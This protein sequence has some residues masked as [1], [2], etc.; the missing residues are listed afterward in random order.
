MSTICIGGAGA[1]AEAR[2]ELERAVAGGGVVLF[3]ADGVYGLGCDPLSSAAIGRIHEIK[4][5]DEGKPAAILYFS[6]LA[7][8]ELLPSLGPRTQDAIGALLP[9]PLTLVVA[10]PD[11]RYPL[12]C[13]EDAERLGIRLID[14]P[15]A[16]A[17]C[18]LFQTSANRSGEP[19]AARFDQ[20]PAAIVE[21]VDLAIDDGELTG[22]PSTV[23]DLTTIESGGG[24][25]ILRPGSISADQLARSLEVLG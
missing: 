8:R 15:L 17:A 18:P 2:S 4:G 21:T 24:P 23:V 9:G 20:I 14:G 19:P 25:K 11:R 1:V 7:L 5:R 13:R 16:G 6:P 12:A 10:N 3:P 22:S